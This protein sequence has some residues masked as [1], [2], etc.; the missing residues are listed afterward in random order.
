MS[1]TEFHGIL[2]STLNYM[3]VV[4][5]ALNE[6]L[7]TATMLASKSIVSLAKC[8]NIKGPLSQNNCNAIKFGHIKPNLNRANNVLNSFVNMLY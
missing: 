8:N 3:R 4:E 2:L 1:T 5:V 7:K 6:P